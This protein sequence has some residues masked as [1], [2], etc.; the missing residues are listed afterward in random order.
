MKDLARLAVESHPLII[1]EATLLVET[2]RYKEFEGLIVVDC[3][4]ELRRKR[5][6]ERDH[7]NSA[8]VQGM[9]SSQASDDARKSVATLILDNSGTLASL[10]KKV[11][12][13]SNRLKSIEVQ[14][15]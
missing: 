2:G 15:S 12:E 13:I 1:Y 5:L 8:V 6:L 7:S 9:L 10:Q 3:P 14:L 11:R 4:L